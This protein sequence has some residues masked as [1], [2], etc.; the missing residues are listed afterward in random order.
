[1][2]KFVLSLFLLFYSAHYT[3]GQVINITKSI[4]TL[5]AVPTK[6]PFNGIILVAQNETTLYSKVYGYSDIDNKTPLKIDDQFVIGSISKQIT[7]VLV[8]REYEKGHLQLNV[9]IRKYLP[10]MP[11]T[12]ADSVTIHQLLTD[13]KST[14]LNSS[15]ST[16]SRMPSSA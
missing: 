13:R 9:P 8:L 7:A 5:L 15:H 14:R 12:W 11:E 16:L 1:M 2:T 6:K 10:E 3:S 4:D